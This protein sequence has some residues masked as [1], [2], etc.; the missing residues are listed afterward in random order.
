MARQMQ[1]GAGVNAADT[2]RT[3]PAGEKHSAAPS[4]KSLV[5]KERPGIQ[6][7][8]VRTRHSMTDD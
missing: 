6:V 8:S 1:V 4:Q 7:E 2:H 5:R 3:A